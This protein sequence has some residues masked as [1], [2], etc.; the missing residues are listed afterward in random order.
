MSMAMRW[1]TALLL[2]GWLGVAHA[3]TAEEC[4]RTT[5]PEGT[6]LSQHL[7]DYAQECLGGQPAAGVRALGVG[8]DAA[9]QDAS[10]FVR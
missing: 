8:A 3:L 7:R 4:K 6:T 5:L 1:I 2:A 10:V 9:A